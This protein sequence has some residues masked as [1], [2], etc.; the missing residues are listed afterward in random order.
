MDAIVTLENLAALLSLIYVLL[1][2][3]GNI[4]CWPA[5][6]VSTAIYT[7]LFFDVNLLMDSGLQ[8]YYIAMAIYGWFNWKK[9]QNQNQTQ[10]QIKSWSKKQH[11]IWITTLGLLTLTLGFIMANY[12]Q[13]D[14]AYLDTLTTVFAVFATYLVAQRVLENWLYWIVIDAISVYLYTSKSLDTTS[15]LFIGYTLIAIWGYW[16][17]RQTYL[18]Q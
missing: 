7:W 6:L 3:K 15:Y 13:A 11:L 18:K 2:A 1:A 5:A 10:I 4:W 14:F 9:S 8:V 17:W 16:Q 12:T